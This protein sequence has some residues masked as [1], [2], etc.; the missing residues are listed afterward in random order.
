MIDTVILMLPREKATVIS[1]AHGMPAWDLQSSTKAYKKFV[2]NPSKEDEASGLY[3]PRL[4][5]Y[6]RR[7]QNGFESTIRIEFSAPKLLYKN[8]LDELEDS[9]FAELIDTLRG[10]LRDLGVLVAVNDIATAEVRAVHFS[11][12]IELRDGYSSRY[13]ISELGKINL[14][15]RFDMTRARYINE[16]QSLYAYT[17]THSVVLYDKIADLRRG[18]KRAIDKENTK[19]QLGLFAVL[20]KRADILRFEVRLSQARKMKSLLTELGFPEQLT[21]RDVFSR[22]KSQAVLNHYWKGMVCDDSLP[23]FAHAMSSKDV[24]RQILQIKRGAKRKE[25]VYLT[26]L[27]LL[28]QES[29]GMRKLREMLS[30]RVHDRSWYRLVRDL[31]DISPKLETVE[32]RG[33]YE[34]VSNALLQYQTYRIPMHENAVS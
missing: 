29:G 22:K 31:R 10:R 33:W 12:N 1:S 4:T 32:R 2:K 16:G 5:G 6:R 17:T 24:F 26:G 8:N 28:S 3:F 13:V 30:K 14:N 7:G 19:F 34:T 15:Q 20:K 11:K 27:V 25:A 9:Q 23:L 21:F 18:N